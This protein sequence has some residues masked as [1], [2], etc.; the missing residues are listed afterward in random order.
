MTAVTTKT[1]R[2]RASVPAP[3]AGVSSSAGLDALTGGGPVS[4]VVD[5]A[6]DLIHPHPHNPR[7]DLGDLTELTDSIRA[8]GIRQNLLL[9]P[10]LDEPG[11]FRAVIGHRRH[12]AAVL[13]G[14]SVVPAAVD[15]GLSPAQQLEL[16]LLENLQRTDLTPVEEGDGYQGLLDLGVDVAAIATSTGRSE[17]TVRSRLRLRA[18]PESAR[19]VVHE[20]QATL[21]D[22]EL[23][24]RTLDRPDVQAKPELARE[25][26]E[27][28]GGEDFRSVVEGEVAQLERDAER[29]ALVEGLTTAGVRMVEPDE[30]GGPPKGVKRLYE[31]TD[32]PKGY[33][34]KGLDE[35]QHAACPGRVAWLHRWAAQVQ[36]GCEGWAQHGHRDRYA[37]TSTSTSSSKVG[38]PDRKTL[39]ANNKVQAGQEPVRRRWLHEWITAH[40]VEG[41]P[42]DAVVYAARVVRPG[43]SLAYPHVFIYDELRYGK[44]LSERDRLADLTDANRA[45]AHLVALAAAVVEAYLHKDFW[46]NPSPHQVAY[47]AQLQGWGYELSAVEAD[48]VKRAASKGKV[49]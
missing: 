20:H 38:G 44:T 28:F 17:S 35:E 19:A 18:L 14:L 47:L 37:S 31:L 4:G 36:Y 1:R 26:E 22:A 33:G 48:V 40:L 29:A 11:T 43:E 8:H 49:R 45:I 32:D 34:G 25:I 6:V 27:A 21:D 7:R 2:K 9:V 5:V 23:L 46:R 3:E 13:A 16:M 12:A 39:V 42:D 41:F 10:D 30:W 24:A 15:P